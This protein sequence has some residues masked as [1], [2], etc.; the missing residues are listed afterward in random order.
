VDVRRLIAIGRTWF[1]VLVVSLVLAAVAA[2]GISM[3]QAKVYEAKATLIVGQSL[4]SPNPDYTQLLASQ[5]LAS[6]YASVATHRPHLEAVIAKLGLAT[7]PVELSKRIAAV[8]PVDSSLVVITAQAQSPTEAAAVANSLADELVAASPTIQGRQAD[9]QASVEED[10]RST[11]AQVLATQAQIDS[12]TGLTDRTPEQ[13]AQLETLENRLVTLRS[14]Y[15]TLLSYVSASASNLLSISEPAIAPDSAVAPRPLLNAFL[16]G[17]LG[18][19]LAVAVAVGVEFFRDPI[20][21]IDDVQAVTGLSTLGIVGRMKGDDR[22]HEMY[23][24]AGLLYPRSAVSEAYRALR[25]NLDFASLDQPVRTLLVTSAMPGEGKTVTAAN[26][27]VVLAQAGRRVILVDADLRK[28]GVHVMFGL[29]NTHGLTSL[30]HL[31]G[32][33]VESAVQMTEQENLSVITTGPLPPNPAEL[34]GTQRMRSILNDLAAQCDVVVVDSPPVQAVADALILGS[35]MDG[36]LFVV[37]ASRSRRRSV[38]RAREALDRAGAR[39]LG[40]VLNRVALG[41]QERYAG[42]YVEPVESTAGA[43]DSRAT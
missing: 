9:L 32:T 4:T 2:F 14:T 31:Q 36:T 19:L 26:L 35:F 17:L 15:A 34:L 41:A 18:L 39:V 29:R 38:H 23:H 27:A 7:T 16:A 22:R 21:D 13:E 37:D 6:T 20:K 3:A 33:A 5:Q 10:L 28:P 1:P 30:I 11:Q 12:L 40:V 42:Y 8:A 43:T 24:L 25:A